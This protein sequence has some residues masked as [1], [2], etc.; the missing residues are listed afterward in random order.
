M[1]GKNYYEILGVKKDATDKDIKQA[2]RRLARKYHPD[3]NPGDKSAEAKFKEINAAY[4]VLSDKEKRHKYDK[5]GDKWQY[6]DQF[7]QAAAAAVAVL[8]VFPGRRHQLP[9]RRGY[10]RHGQHLR[11]AVRGR[12]LP[13]LFPPL[14]AETRTGPGIARRGNARRSL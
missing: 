4:E 2:Y 3:V 14:P 7:E 8:R 6:A 12:A 5:Y 9:L 1:A 13:G 11:G 10:R